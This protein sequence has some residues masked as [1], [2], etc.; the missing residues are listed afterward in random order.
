MNEYLLD[1][2][3]CIFLLKDKYKIAEKIDA[4][5]IENCYVSEITIGELLFGAEYSENPEK[6]REEVV[7]FEENFKVIPLYTAL[8]FYAKEKAR[9]RKSGQTIAEFDLLI[10]STAVVNNLIAVTRNQKHFS[11]IS[12]IQLEDWTD[13]AFNEFL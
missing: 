6:H 4:V 1:T 7:F 2:D 8:R 13:K 3:T 5:G 11:R 12:G 9:L 10:G